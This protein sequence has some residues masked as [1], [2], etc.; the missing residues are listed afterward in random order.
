MSLAILQAMARV[1]NWYKDV[2][3]KPACDSEEYLSERSDHSRYLYHQLKR[4]HRLEI[5]QCCMIANIRI[6]AKINEATQHSRQ[7][8]NIV[9]ESS[10]QTSDDLDEECASRWQVNV[11]SESKILSQD[12]PHLK[13]VVGIAGEV[14]ICQWHWLACTVYYLDTCNTDSQGAFR[15]T[16]IQQASV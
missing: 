16:C 9:E 4:E 2:R 1:L 11:L 14:K 8:H 5:E 7:H 10:D 6:N 3:G 13:R 15:E 12:L